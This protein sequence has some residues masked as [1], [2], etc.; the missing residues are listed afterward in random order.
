[1]KDR[2]KENFSQRRKVAKKEM[3]SEN[4]RKSPA[5]IHLTNLKLLK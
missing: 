1:M 3:K 5:I 4:R 2:K